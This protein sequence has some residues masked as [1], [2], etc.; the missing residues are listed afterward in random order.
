MPFTPK[1]WQD[2]RAGGTPV[3]AA[4]LVDLETRLSQYTDGQVGGSLLVRDEGTIV[5]NTTL[6]MSGWGEAMW[7][8][9]LGANNIKLGIIGQ[10][11]GAATTVII[12]QDAVGGRTLH[13]TQ[14]LPL[15]RWEG[16]AEPTQTLT[17][18]S[19]DIRAFLFD[20]TDLFG[21][22]AGTNMA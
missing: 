5:A 3:N 7:I 11:P 14:G 15:A 21:W 19:R 18:N 22:D 16:G 6:D 17:A 10:Q 1:P 4:A 2:G 13:A 20:G 8:V 9:T 12:R